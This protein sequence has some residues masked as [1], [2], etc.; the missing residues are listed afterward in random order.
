M[1]CRSFV[2][3]NQKPSAVIRLLALL[4]V[5]CLGN[6]SALHA[7][8]PFADIDVDGNLLIQE[9]LDD[10][11]DFDVDD[12]VEHGTSVYC[13]EWNGFLSSLVQIMELRNSGGGAVN[14]QI[15]LFSRAGTASSAATVTIPPMR[16]FDYVVNNAPGFTN[17]TYGLVC[18]TITNQIQDSLD[19]QLSTYRL[20]GDGFELDGFSLAYSVPASSGRFG[21]QFVGYNHIYPTA[22]P[23]ELNN[24]AAGYV[25][26]SNIEATTESGQLIFY[27][28]EGFERRRVSVVLPA[29]GR[30]DVD[31]HSLGANTVGRVEWAPNASDKRF[32]VVLNRYFY[33]SNATGALIGAVAIPAKIGSGAVSGAPFSLDGKIAVIE[34]VNALDVQT[35]VELAVTR[36]DGTPAATQPP[37]LVLPPRATR[38]VVLNSFL[39]AGIGGRVTVSGVPAGSVVATS[40][41]YGL[42]QTLGFVYASNADVAPAVTVQQLVSYNNFL[43]GCDLRLVNLSS[44]ALTA[45]F[46][47]TRYDGTNIPLADRVVPADG[48]VV[49]DVCSAD[50][51]SAYGEISITTAAKGLVA[52]I[53]RKSRNSDAEFRLPAK[54]RGKYETW[55]EVTPSQLT[56]TAG[57]N[58]PGSFTVTNL[59]LLGGTAKNIR[60]ILD[61]SLSDVSS[62]PNQCPVL[63]AAQSCSLSV[64]PGNSTHPATDVTIT[65]DNSIPAEASVEVVP[66]QATI[67]SNPTSLTIPENSTEF[68]TITNSLSSPIVANNIAAAIPLG[69]AITVQSTTC[70]ATLAIGASCTITFASVNQEGPTSISV[71]G[72]NTNTLTVATT[73]TPLP[74]IAIAGPAQASRIVSTDG[75]SQLNLEVTNDSDSIFNAN[76]ITVTDKTACPNLSVDASNCTSVAPG[77]SCQLALTTTTP[78]S[79]C[80]IS[81]GGSNT[82]NTP[83]TLI[84][85]SHL[86]GI[87]FQTSGANGKVVIDA[88]SE[89]TSEWTFPSKASVPGATS[90]DDGVSNTNAIVVDTACTNQTA[91]CAANRCRAISADWYLPARNELTAVTTALC[92]GAAYPCAFGAFSSASYWSSTEWFAATNAYAVDVPS[93]NSAPSDKWSSF[94]V[95]C[96]RSF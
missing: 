96:I 30:I 42:D 91:N 69:S 12:F 43:G 90:D 80:T 3:R 68:I 61:P 81:I 8:V 59:S 84:A 72:D 62:A 28:Q 10:T 56:L 1:L 16:Q 88:A 20:S 29:F 47:M 23:S 22:N 92:P 9:A 67:S 50:T 55:L 63:A 6:A 76:N 11:S 52:E 54:P 24:F 57:T 45:E 95:R 89:F 4:V 58:T 79:P 19:A 33:D 86:G 51:Q 93:G 36:A 18:A 7:A 77:A 2:S 85:F 34:L 53:V 94:A 75:V 35:S 40:F 15:R 60:V 32:R 13:A 66:L 44:S 39:P 46:R 65:A 83:T 64:L 37:L 41:E 5:F 49:V 27:N 38:H 78:Y 14:V 17:N 25:Q 48:A 31:T 71:A 21:K 74:V 82:A 73:V 87:V 26:V 70:G